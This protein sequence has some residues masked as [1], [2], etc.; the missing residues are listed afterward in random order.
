MR[1]LIYSLLVILITTTTV[2]A[3]PPEVRRLYYGKDSSE[4]TMTFRHKV[5]IEY[6]QGISFE[7]MEERIQLQIKHMFG[8]MSNGAS[9]AVPKEDHQITIDKDITAEKNLKGN[10]LTVYYEYSGTVVADNSAG[11]SLDIT[12]P[13]DPKRVYAQG[14]IERNGTASFPCTDTH[15]T[16]EG[17]FWYFWG[18]T[19]SGCPL[20]LNQTYHTVKTTLKRKANTEKTYPEYDRLVNEEGE[21]VIY[22]FFGMAGHEGTKSPYTNRDENADQYKQL[23]SYLTGSAGFKVS[24][25]DEN[26]NYYIENLELEAEKANIKV[27]MYFGETGINDHAVNKF[28]ELYKNAIENSSIMLYNGHSGL[29]GNLHLEYLSYAINKKINPKPG[30][31]QIYYFNSCSS[32]PYYNKMYFTPKASANDPKG[33]KSLDIITNGLSTYFYVMGQTSQN[34]VKMVSIWANSGRAYSWQEF[35]DGSDSD[36]LIGING[37]EDN[38]T[39]PPR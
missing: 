2:S 18:P 13:L 26:S 15:Y 31:Y 6:F 16:S 21:I 24:S 33:T 22:A 32:Y 29:G 5:E 14:T 9:K 3:A 19:Q 35:I 17:D 10:I 11:T 36:N 4:A 30:K 39:T 20:K 7:V 28:H 34:L 12:L 25:T 27:I 37:D 38:P 8:P 23:K 1:K